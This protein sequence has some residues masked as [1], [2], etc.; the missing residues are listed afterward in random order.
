MRSSLVRKQSGCFCL[1]VIMYSNFL[2][3]HS[4]PEAVFLWNL[5]TGKWC[6]VVLHILLPSVK[7][8]RPSL[9]CFLLAVRTNPH[10]RCLHLLQ[11]VA[12]HTP[13]APPPEGALWPCRTV[14]PGCT[15]GMEEAFLWHLWLHS[16]SPESGQHSP[17]PWFHPESQT[18]S[19]FTPTK[20]KNHP[21]ST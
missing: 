4:P 3:T 7:P 6:L 19:G 8:L 9:Q 16:D 14:Q 21:F 17:G 10:G 13:P 2:C 11:W 5:T 12:G 18:E 1:V 15:P 20:K